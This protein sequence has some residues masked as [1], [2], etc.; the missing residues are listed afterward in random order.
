MQGGGGGGGGNKSLSHFSLPN[1]IYP[2]FISLVKH[3][4]ISDS[5]PLHV[6]LSNNKLWNVQCLYFTRFKSM[7]HEIMLYLP[8]IAQPRKWKPR[9][10]CVHPVSYPGI[11]IFSSCYSWIIFPSSLTLPCILHTPLPSLST[12]FPCFV[13]FP[14]LPGAEGR[15]EVNMSEVTLEEVE[16]SLLEKDPSVTPGGYWKPKDCLPRWKVHTTDTSL[17]LMKQRLHF[18]PE[19]SKCV[20]KWKLMH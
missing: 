6:F 16:R 8:R 1:S 14:F 20:Y 10:L 9:L 12:F 3:P 17:Y 13:F 5:R 19:E 2:D 4:L 15:L 11:K 7:M 18:L